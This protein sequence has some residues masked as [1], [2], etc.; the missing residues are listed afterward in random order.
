MYWTTL[1][2]P[3]QHREQP[4]DRAPSASIG[5]GCNCSTAVAY[6]EENPS[7]LDTSFCCQS[8]EDLLR[9][10]ALQHLPDNK[11]ILQS[12]LI[13]DDLVY[14]APVLEWDAATLLSALES[15]KKQ[16]AQYIGFDLIEDMVSCSGNPQTASLDY[17]KFEREL[18][19]SI[20]V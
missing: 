4:N 5:K 14:L 2:P 18:V 16:I 10:K 1:E 7:R 12:I 15:N 6:V 13:K 17:L 8:Y 20:S 11:F 9:L 3:G 19:C